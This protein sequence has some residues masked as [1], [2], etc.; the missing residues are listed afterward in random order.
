MSETSLLDKVASQLMLFE[1]S[2]GKQ[3]KMI[4]LAG[5]ELQVYMRLV[6]QARTF[7]SRPLPYHVDK[8]GKGHQMERV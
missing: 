8:V 3:N 1:Q 6:Y 7:L 2:I 5:V 4:L